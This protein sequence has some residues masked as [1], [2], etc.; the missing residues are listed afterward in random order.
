LERNQLIAIVVI[1]VVVVGAGVAFFYF[2]QPTRPPEDTLVWETIGNPQYLDPHVDYESYGSSVSYNV[3]ETL[4]TYPFGTAETAPSVPLLAASAPVWA[5]DGLSVNITLRQGIKFHDGTP[6]NASCVKWNWERAMKIF[7]TDGPVWMFAEPIKGG[8]VLEGIAFDQGP[9]SPE[10]A[11][12]FDNWVANVTWID[13]F[14]QYHIRLNLE[15]SYVP[16]IAAITYEVGAVMSPTYAITHGT[17]DNSPVDMSHYG[18]DYGEYNGYMAQHTCGTGPYMVEEWLP[19]QWI[20]MKLNENYW[21]ADSTRTDLTSPVDIRP[22]SYSGSIKSVYL[23]TNE[24]VTTRILNVRAGVT[25]GCYLPYTNAADL[26]TLQ[27]G[28]GGGTDRYTDV[29][30]SYGGT[31]Y[32]VEHFGFRSGTV[33]NFN[34][35]NVNLTSP[36]ADINL[37]LAFSYAFNDSAYMAA[38][39]YGFGVQAQGIIPMGLFGHVDDLPMYHTNMTAAVLYWNLAMANSATKTAYEAFESHGGLTLYYNSGNTRREQACLIMKDSIQKL[40]GES[41]ITKITTATA[42][43]LTINVQSLEWSNYLLQQ[44]NL[45]MAVWI[46][47]WIPDYADPDNFVFP[48][49]YDH[50]TFAYRLGYNNTNVNAWY[51]ETRGEQNATHRAEL[52]RNIEFA[53]YNDVPYRMVLQGGELRCWRTWLFGQGKNWNPMT[54]S[55]GDWGYIFDL[56]KTYPT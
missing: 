34:G 1:V 54:T 23:K 44:R 42:D 30:V 35:Q 33:Y 27:A 38:A 22:E 37:R 49:A 18:V 25:D 8:A 5:A 48:Y 11:A 15:E 10:F 3:Y 4:Y 32:F 39:V 40:Y 52:F 36:F 43:E 41:N 50:G 13:I 20:Y 19:N 53:V 51:E 31:S 46:I 21:R 14:D 55:G 47:G 9:D 7:Y 2:S 26:L 17:T 24:D 56:Y 6:F 45:A 12:A 16:F 29:H 28:G